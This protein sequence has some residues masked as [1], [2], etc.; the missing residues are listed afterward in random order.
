MK[1]LEGDENSGING[2]VSRWLLAILA[3]VV[4]GGVAILLLGHS[5]S[6]AATPKQLAE[7]DVAE[8]LAA[9]PL[10]PGT[11]RVD[12]LPKSLDLD[13]PGQEPATPNLV[14]RGA[15]YVSSLSPTKALAWFEAHPP[16]DSA[17][18]GGGT[19]ATFG[20]GVVEQEVEDSWP[21]LPAVRERKLLV[22]VAGRPGGGSAIRLDAQAVWAKPHPTAARIPA[23]VHL[24]ELE[25]R[26]AGREEALVRVAGPAEIA[27]FVGWV[28][29]AEAAQPGKRECPRSPARPHELIITFR[30]APGS[31]ILAR[32]A[33]NVPTGCQPLL[34]MVK[35]QKATAL[36]PNPALTR[37]ALKRLGIKA[38]DAG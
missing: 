23:G 34:L 5:D 35:G 19:T 36:E 13:G 24:V 20:G 29:G 16:T 8:R 12:S 1:P 25:Y 9:A 2:M 21:D 37:R 3:L 10:P 26:Y 11:E 31:H 18:T 14:D 15:Q 6:S 32:A 4:A 22:A 33:Q 30:T 38:G 7:R 27:K 17:R 28:D